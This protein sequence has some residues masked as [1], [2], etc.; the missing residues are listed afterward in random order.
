MEPSVQLL[1]V[2]GAELFLPFDGQTLHV[3]LPG[4]PERYVPGGQIEQKV[5][6]LLWLV[7]EPGG[8]D[9]HSPG[10]AS[11]LYVPT[12]HG[13]HGPPAGPPYPALQTQ[14]VLSSEDGKEVELAG[15]FKHPCCAEW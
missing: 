12:L 8:H 2:L 7:N 1:Q 4:T 6:A 13:E 9:L 11:R 14:L 3:T 15:H 5:L 10:P